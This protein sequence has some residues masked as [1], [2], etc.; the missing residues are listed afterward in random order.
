[1]DR[2]DFLFVLAGLAAA[3]ALAAAPFVPRRFTVRSQGRGPDIIFIPGLTSGREVWQA[4]AAS[5]AGYRSHLL[6]VCGFAGEPAGANKRGPLLVPLAEEIAA[7][8]SASGMVRPAIVGHS[9]GGTLALM[10]AARHPQ[11]VGRVMVVDMLP[12]PA[13]LFGGNA[14]DLGAMASGFGAMLS[15]PG[16]RQLFANILGA[17][18]PPQ[19]AQRSDPDVV[20]EAMSEL[21]ALDLT[22]QLGRIRSPLTVVYASPDPAARAVLDRTFARAYA[23]ARSVRLVR[24]DGSGHMIMHDQP[25]RFVAALRAFLAR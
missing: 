23:A 22:A 6:Q 25:A 1:M 9:M 10:L 8:I 4:A 12:Q 21:A 7:Y 15:T 3:P 24:V 5:L 2:R 20:A 18:S 17:F 13:G 19:V 11:L 16:G 14:R